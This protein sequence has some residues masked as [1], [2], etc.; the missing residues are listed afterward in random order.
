MRRVIIFAVLVTCV[1]LAGCD[2]DYYDPSYYKVENTYHHSTPGENYMSSLVRALVVDN[3]SA[4]E[5]AQSFDHYD[6]WKSSFKTDSYVHGDKSLWDAGAEWTVNYVEAVKGV[7]IK[8]EA[9]DSTWSMTR[10]KLYK[11]NSFDYPTDYTLILHMLPGGVY[12]HHNWEVT[13]TNIERTERDGYSCHSW[14]DGPVS[15]L[16]A[17]SDYWGSFSGQIY[18]TVKK[19]S[20]VIDNAFLAFVGNSDTFYFRD[21]H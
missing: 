21:L 11:V 2:R 3:L 1:L 13:I 17:D 18:L 19:G 7:K 6:L 15:V 5:S 16:V 12:N 4:M 20:E 10:S 8:K 9:A 14:S